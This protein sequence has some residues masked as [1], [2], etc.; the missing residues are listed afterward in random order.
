MNRIFQ[1]A[2][3]LLCLSLTS[4]QKGCPKDG[5]AKKDEP[6]EAK[7]PLIKEFPK[8][9]LTGLSDA[10]RKSL[11]TLFNEEVCPCGCPSTFAQCINEKGC[12]PGELLAQWTI[13]RLKEGAPEHYLYKAVTSEVNTGY[14]ANKVDINT[15]GAYQK[16]SKNASLTIIEFADF[17]CPMCKFASAEMNE[18]VKKNPD[19][20]IYFMHYPLNTHPNAERAALAAE[21]AGKLGKFWEL[22]DLMFAFN[23]PLTDTSIKSLAQ[24][25]FS[26]K[27]LALF[28]KHLADP[29]LR[30]KIDSHKAYAVNELKLS[31]TPT[32]LFNG[33]PY[34][35]SSSIDGYELRLAMEKAR[36]EID[37]NAK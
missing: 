12:K 1:L 11:T 19:V 9:N 37:C 8:L 4:C 5:V 6:V 17:E 35:L 30:K 7:E 27:E 23:G 36:Q 25:I 10:Q 34:N 20:E 18:F 22:H 14:L 28:E 13:D 2:L 16:G 26:M 32:F 3:G 24:K 29:E 33:R 15:L 31:G 21:A